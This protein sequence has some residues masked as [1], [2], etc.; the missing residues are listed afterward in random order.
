MD[1][2]MKIT[3]SQCRFAMISALFVVVCVCVGITMNLTTQYDENFDHM[4]LRTFCMFTVNSNILVAKSVAVASIGNCPP[5]KLI[6]F[7]VSSLAFLVI[8]HNAPDT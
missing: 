3:R 5:A 2:V 7:T 4:G 8:C 1:R 6:S